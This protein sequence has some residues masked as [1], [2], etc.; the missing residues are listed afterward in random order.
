MSCACSNRDGRFTLAEMRQFVDLGRLRSRVY[1]PYEFPAQM[2]GYC[3]IQLWKW[4]A[5]EGGAKAFEDWCAHVLA[6]LCNSCKEAILVRPCGSFL[7]FFRPAALL[8]CNMCSS[9]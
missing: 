4:A 8:E 1:Q 3:T 9:G 7:P 5:A 2:Q 6:S